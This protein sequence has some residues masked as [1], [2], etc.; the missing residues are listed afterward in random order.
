MDWRTVSIRRATMTSAVV[1][2]ALGVM[3][4]HLLEMFGNFLVVATTILA[5]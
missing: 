4:L 3:L 2:V 5:C 1:L